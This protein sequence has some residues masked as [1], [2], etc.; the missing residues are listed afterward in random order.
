MK[1]KLKCNSP[2]L[3]TVRD[4]LSDRRAIRIAQDALPRPAIRKASL[5]RRGQDAP[6]NMPAVFY[7]LRWAAPLKV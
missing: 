7:V 3:F 6:S 4:T 5:L 2:L 1:A